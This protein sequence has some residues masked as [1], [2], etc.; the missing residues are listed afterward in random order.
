MFYAFITSRYERRSIII[1]TNRSI[2]EWATYLGNDV[3]CCEACIDRFL[4]HSFRIRF[5]GK[6]YRLA[7]IRNERVSSDV[8]KQEIAKAVGEI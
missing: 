2:S 3:K 7:A 5:T 1:T 4:H 6:S 8:D